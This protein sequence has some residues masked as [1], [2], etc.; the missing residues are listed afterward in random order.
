M[1]ILE[2]L[3]H[4]YTEP[5]NISPSTNLKYIW[6]NLWLVLLLPVRCL[7]EKFSPFF[8]GKQSSKSTYEI[9]RRKR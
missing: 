8:S 1:E 5:F 6:A 2:K 4:I 3:L 7:Q 9:F